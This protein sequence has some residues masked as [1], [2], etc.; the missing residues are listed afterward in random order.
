MG[1][2]ILIGQQN[3]EGFTLVETLVAVTVLLVVII[4]PMTIAQKG[5]QNAYYAREQLIAVSLAQEAVEG[6]RELRDIQALKV[7]ENSAVD[8]EAWLPSTCGGGNCAYVPGT[9]GQVGSVSTCGSGN[10]YCVLKYDV[11]TKTYA[12]DVVGGGNNSIF[13]RKITI[14]S[15][16][17]NGGVGASSTV[18]WTGKIFGGTTRQVVLQTWIYDHYQRYED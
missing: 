13:T 6:I 14:R 11:E 5:I 2:H 8:T 3:T 12:H 18:E 17:V 4:G 15:T 9:Q 7:Y 10:N 1:M 16:P